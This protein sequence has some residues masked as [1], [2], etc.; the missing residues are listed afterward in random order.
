MRFGV[1][2]LVFGV[3]V[4]VQGCHGCVSRGKAVPYHRG[5]PLARGSTG[6]T[7][8]APLDNHPTSKHQTLNTK[9]P[10]GFT[11]AAA[12]PW[13]PCPSCPC[14]CPCRPAPPSRPPAP[15]PPPPGPRG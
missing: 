14:P 15:S 6:D 11:P 2:C 8:V 1:W 10:S 3:W 13:A 5:R 12:A 4:V 9:H 7:P